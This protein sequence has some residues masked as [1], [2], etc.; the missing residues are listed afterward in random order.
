MALILWHY[1]Q[2]AQLTEDERQ[3]LIQWTGHSGDRKIFLNNLVSH[4]KWM[5][6]T[7]TEFL[8]EFEGTITQIKSRLESV[9]S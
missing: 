2:G 1:Q 9:Q 3:K 7:L 4:K 6:V 8:D 5:E